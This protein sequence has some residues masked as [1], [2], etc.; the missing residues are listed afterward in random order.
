MRSS[1]ICAKLIS[2]HF[3]VFSNLAMGNKIIYNRNDCFDSIITE[4][5]INNEL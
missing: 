1:K 4:I 3:S 5:L 2:D